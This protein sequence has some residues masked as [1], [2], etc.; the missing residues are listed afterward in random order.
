M[1]PRMKLNKNVLAANAILISFQRSRLKWNK[2]VL[3]AKT[4]LFLFRR[5]SILK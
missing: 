1:E 5:G 4:F 3:A 2:I